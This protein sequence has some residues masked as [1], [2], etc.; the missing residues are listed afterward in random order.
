M[1]PDVLGNRV[2]AAC[3]LVV[4]LMSAIFFTA[5]LYLPQFMEVVLHYSAIRSGAGLAPMMAVFAA[6]SFVAGARL[7][8]GRRLIPAITGSARSRGKRIRPAAADRVRV[9]A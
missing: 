6:T 3:C 2:F 8:T 5:L 9:A 1:P 7:R 4:L